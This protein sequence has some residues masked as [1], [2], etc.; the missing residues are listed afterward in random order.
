MQECKNAQSLKCV[1]SLKYEQTLKC[2]LSLHTGCCDAVGSVVGG[3][4]WWWWGGVG[5]APHV[6]GRSA[7]DQDVKTGWAT[8]I[9]RTRVNSSLGHQTIVYYYYY[10]YYYSV[11]VLCLRGVLHRGIPYATHHYTPYATHH[12]TPYATDGMVRT[13]N[14]SLQRDVTNTPT[15][16]NTH[17]THPEVP[18]VV[19][20]TH[21]WYGLYAALARV[22]K[23][24]PT[25]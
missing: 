4:W 21:T 9:A 24:N 2:K 19:H 13:R 10:Y 3:R 7:V 25:W 8:H 1:Q 20:N 14:T 16:P 5:C 23:P 18:F 22:R 6:M 17:N 15:H 12:Y 11:A